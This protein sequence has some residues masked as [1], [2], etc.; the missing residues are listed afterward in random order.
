MELVNITVNQVRNLVG[1]AVS[2]CTSCAGEID[3]AEIVRC[4]LDDDLILDPPRVALI[5]ALCRKVALAPTIL[6]RYCQD[7]V[8]SSSAAPLPQVEQAKLAAAFLRFATL[9]GHADENVR[10]VALKCLNG[11]FTL[12]NKTQDQ[13]TKLPMSNELRTAANALVA[14]VK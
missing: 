7:W 12:L 8:K 14:S 13:A 9:H 3:V 10:G 11:V 2:S 4:L 6:D 1:S 5:N